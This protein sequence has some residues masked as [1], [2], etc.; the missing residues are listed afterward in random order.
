M[1]NKK[2]KLLG[3]LLLALVLCLAFTATALAKAGDPPA[4]S[5]SVEDNED[6]TYQIELSVTGEAD[7]E[8]EPVKANVIIVLDTSGSMDFLLPSTTGSYGE[9]TQDGDTRY[10]SFQLYRRSNGNRY[11][12]ITDAEAY[13]G[14]V[15]SNYYGNYYEY[16]GTRYSATSRMDATKTSVNNLIDTLASQNTTAH[17]DTIEMALITFESDGH[18]NTPNS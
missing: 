8:S 7:Y 6:G 17:P 11:T 1:K 16:T 9:W 14:T 18:Y 10:D 15:Y 2:F 13:T 12:A 5:K 3:C 4:N